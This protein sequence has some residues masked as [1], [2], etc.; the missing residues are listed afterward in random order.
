METPNT[1]KS[2][3]QHPSTPDAREP[4]VPPKVE[5]KRSLQKVTLLSGMAQSAVGV[6]AVSG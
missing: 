2:V 4:Y 5:K 1:K 6:I 3:D